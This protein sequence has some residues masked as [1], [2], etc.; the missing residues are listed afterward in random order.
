MGTNEADGSFPSQI[1]HIWNYSDHYPDAGGAALFVE[2]PR[3]AFQQYATNDTVA[4]GA[5]NCDIYS[6]S[7]LSRDDGF[8]TTDTRAR[9]R[10]TGTSGFDDESLVL[11]QADSISLA[12]ALELGYSGP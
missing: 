1:A 3:Y 11:C 12:G 4:K 8:S 7:P 9:I 6:Y 5:T 2:S 10:V